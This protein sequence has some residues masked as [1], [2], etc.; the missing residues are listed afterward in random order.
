[1]KSHGAEKSSILCDVFEAVVG[2]IFKD[3]GYYEAENFILNSV[4]NDVADI[5]D[6]D[7]KSKLQEYVQN[8]NLELEYVLVEETGADHEKN[9]TVAVH[10]SGKE[11][12]RA[13][14]KSKKAA[15]QKAA[16]ITLKK[17]KVYV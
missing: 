7:T 5:K 16:G 12:A 15:E 17:L 10:I 4:L 13:S 14:A 1:M 2:A 6:K 8:K 9:Y 3:G 11:Y